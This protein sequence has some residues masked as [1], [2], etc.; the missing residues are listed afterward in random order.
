MF[1][2]IVKLTNFHRKSVDYDKCAY[3]LQRGT[4][5]RELVYKYCYHD[6]YLAIYIAYQNHARIVDGCS[7]KNTNW[8]I[9]SKMK[10]STCKSVQRTAFGYVIYLQA[11]QLQY[12]VRV[13]YLTAFCIWLFSIIY[14]TCIL[15]KYGCGFGVIKTDFERSH[16][17]KK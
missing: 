3:W 13:S 9:K 16:N 10:Q 1:F 4:G 6:H 14:N 7:S 12:F 17:I 5:E 11:L 8:K 2:G 15:P